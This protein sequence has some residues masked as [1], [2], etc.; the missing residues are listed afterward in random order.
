MNL[1]RSV[2]QRLMAGLILAGTLGAPAYAGDLDN[3]WHLVMRKLPDGTMQTPPTVQGRFTTK[4]G[5]T[6]LIVFWPTPEGKSA[7]LSQIAKWEWSENEVAATPLLVIFDDGTG[8]PPLYAVGG[9]T[10]RVPITRQDGR[11]S[12]QH[13]IDPVFIVWEGEVSE[14]SKMK[15]TLEGA[16]VDYWEK[17]K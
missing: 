6:Q 15:A 12:Y 2:S 7:S 3:T 8:K 11:V 13:P 10:K 5:V 14:A 4:K 16:F 9:E 17:V 1:F